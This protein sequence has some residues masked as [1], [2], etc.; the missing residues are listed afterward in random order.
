MLR[1]GL[2]ELLK[3]NGGVTD[4]YNA[5]NLTTTIKEQ[6]NRDISSEIHHDVK[7]KQQVH[8]FI[9]GVKKLWKQAARKEK[10]FLQTKMAAKK[11][12]AETDKKARHGSWGPSDHL[13]PC[14]YQGPSEYQGPFEHQGSSDHQGPSDHQGRSQL[15]GTL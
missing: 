2:H 1:Q 12:T 6:L 9:V 14:H 15:L 4:G 11:K 10:T 7:V 5:D 3:V 8:W 13:G